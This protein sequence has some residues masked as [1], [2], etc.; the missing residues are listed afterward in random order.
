MKFYR[1]CILTLFIITL[2]LFNIFTEAIPITN[3]DTSIFR[4]DLKRRG[5][6]KT[7][8]NKSRLKLQQSQII[9]KYSKLSKR[10]LQE[11]STSLLLVNEYYMDG[12]YYGTII[13]GGQYFT[14]DFDT[15]SSDL[16]V[17][18]IQCKFSECLFHNRF[19]PKMSP[20]FVLAPHPNNF[21]MVY[22]LDDDT[23]TVV[24]GYIGRDTVTLGGITVTN[25][26]FGLAT[27]DDLGYYEED[28]VI[29]L[30]FPQLSIFEAPSVIQTMKDQKKI[31]K[32]L[33]AFHLG[34]HKLVPDD[35]SFADIGGVDPNAYV[36]EIVYNNLLDSLSCMGYWAITMDDVCVDQVSLGAA[37]SAAIIDTGTTSIWGDSKCVKEIHKKIPGSFFIDVL[38]LW[39]IPCDTKAVVTLVFNNAPF[40]INPVE[41]II[42]EIKL[43]PLCQSAIQEMPEEIPSKIWLIGAFFLSNVYSVFD[44]DNHQIG[45]AKAKVVTSY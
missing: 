34:R 17:P 45:F 37:N 15:G 44:F 20:T 22:G 19:D 38:S 4:I 40:E 30:A 42:Q 26:T 14:V 13:I 43:G 21:T 32:A 36:G 25:Q 7:I 5:I 29:G 39:F 31:N 16:W 33:I 3:E 18:A 10:D 27:Y 23:S 8:P 11:S 28:G 35:K 12:C 6:S 1:C 41:L 2:L 24:C 9:H